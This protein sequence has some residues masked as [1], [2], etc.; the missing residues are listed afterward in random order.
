MAENATA[1]QAT[2]TEAERAQLQFAI[3]QL[4]SQQNLLGGVLGGIA[5]AAVGAALWAGVTV[6]TGYQIG[7]M[8][9]GV[10]FLVGYAVRVFGKGL[11][12]IFGVIGAVL[13]LVGCG[14]GNLLTVCGFVAQQESLAFFDVLTRLDLG[15]AQELMAATFSPMDVLFYGIAV[16]EGYKLSFRRLTE[17]ELGVPPART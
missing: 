10:G 9:V 15:I 17:Q 13:S 14:I 12:P 6:A 1:A 8:A 4:R 3:E 7:W 16:Y 11:D 5:G 2:V